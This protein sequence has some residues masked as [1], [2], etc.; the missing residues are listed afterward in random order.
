MMPIAPKAGMPPEHADEHR[1]RRDSRPPGYQH[2]PQ[3]VVE[4]VKISPQASMKIAKPQ[5]PS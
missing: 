2:R 5:R 3:D 4:P 1:E